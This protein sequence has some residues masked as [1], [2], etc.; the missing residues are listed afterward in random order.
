MWRAIL[1]SSLGLV[2]GVLM[3][4][5]ILGGILSGEAFPKINC[6][7]LASYVHIG[8]SVFWAIAAGYSLELVFDKL[9]SVVQ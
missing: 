5:M 6:E 1:G 8:R 9:R 4:S 7:E 3:Y 2:A